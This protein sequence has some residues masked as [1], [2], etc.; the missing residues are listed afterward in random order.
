MTKE[1]IYIE[2]ED[3]NKTYIGYFEKYTAHLTTDLD[4]WDV[5]IKLDGLKKSE[6]E[7]PDTIFNTQPS[8][9]TE[10]K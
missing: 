8:C 6:K 3:G 7:N 1:N 10:M 5:E 2:R 4:Q 9:M